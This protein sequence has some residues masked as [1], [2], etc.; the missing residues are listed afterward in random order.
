MS[1]LGQY[2]PPAVVCTDRSR[3]GWW[4]RPSMFMPRWACRTVRDVFTVRVERLQK[5]TEADAIAEGAYHDSAQWVCGVGCGATAVE[6]Y[7]VL[8]DALNGDSGHGWDANDWVWVIELG[9]GE[10]H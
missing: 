5:I 7:R 1:Y 2:P 10:S 9:P 4:K 6:A 3:I 8:W